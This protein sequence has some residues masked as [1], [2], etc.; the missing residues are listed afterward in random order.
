MSSVASHHIA[1]IWKATRCVDALGCCC[2]CV[3][4]RKSFW[5]LEV[6]VRKLY[7]I[8]VG[9]FRLD[10]FMLLLFAAAFVVIPYN[11]Y[12]SSSFGIAFRSTGILH[13]LHTLRPYWRNINWTCD[14]HFGMVRNIW[15]GITKT[16]A[17]AVHGLNPSTSCWA[18]QTHSP[19]QWNS[20]VCSFK[21]GPLWCRFYFTLPLHRLALSVYSLGFKFSM[22][23]QRSFAFHLFHSVPLSL[24]PFH[25]RFCCHLQ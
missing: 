7:Q 5:L 4:N 8:P 13:K 20:N 3:Y 22:L 11:I 19:C 23:V 16:A 21:I 10:F 25:S 6:K 24:S 2:V 15:C 18:N 12:F 1:P 14:S 9:V 17:D